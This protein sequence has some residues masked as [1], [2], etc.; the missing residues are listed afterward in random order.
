M[1]TIPIV[2]MARERL[3][4][5]QRRMNLIDPKN[6]TPK[7]PLRF[8]NDRSLFR[9]GAL[10]ALEWRLPHLTDLLS[11]RSHQPRRTES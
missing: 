8:G 5:G 10:N 4:M 7:P 9:A 3:C 2:A 6:K 11:T 1:S